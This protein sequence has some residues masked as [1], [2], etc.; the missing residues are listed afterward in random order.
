M[1][2]GTLVASS[3]RGRYALNTPGGLDITSGR[4]CEIWLCGQWIRGAVEHAG[5]LYADEVTGR[6]ERGYYF[7]GRNGGIC[8]LCAGVRLRIP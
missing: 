7:I 8:G 6:T 4:V 3:N 2:E 5:L 1:R